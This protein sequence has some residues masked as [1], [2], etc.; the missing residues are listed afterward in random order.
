MKKRFTGVQIIGIL[1]ET[2]TGTKVSG[3][4]RTAWHF[5]DAHYN[6]KAKFG[7][8]TVADVQRLKTLEA[9]NA[10]L[11]RFPVVPMLDNTLLKDIVGRKRQG[12]RPGLRQFHL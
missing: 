10:G 4:C 9:K 12:S 8:I 11:M 1:E 3:L 5:D 6:G 7:G 2:H